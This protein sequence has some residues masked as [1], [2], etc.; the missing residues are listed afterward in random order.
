MYVKAATTYLSDLSYCCAVTSSLYTYQTP[1]ILS[2]EVNLPANYPYHS[3]RT[4]WAPFSSPL[5]ES[6]KATSSLSYYVPSQT[7]VMASPYRRYSASFLDVN[8]STELP[9]GLPSQMCGWL[10]HIRED[11]FCQIKLP[12]TIHFCQLAQ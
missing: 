7:V 12:F 8:V 1:H 9:H 11:A 5:F 2:N 4:V 10:M 3:W 6:L